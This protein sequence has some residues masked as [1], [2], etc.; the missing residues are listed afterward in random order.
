MRPVRRVAPVVLAAVLVL[1]IALS[2]SAQTR[3]TGTF[4]NLSPGEQKIVRALFEAQTK[5]GTPKP[6]TLDEIAARKQ[7]YGGWGQVFKSMKAQGL[8]TS[9]SL[10]EV[11]SGYERRHP[12]VAAKPDKARPDRVDKS[13]KPDRPGR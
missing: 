6:L 5:S 7:G 13:D 3:G 11:V 10:G 1:G 4:A 2:A 9:K 8:V 12:V